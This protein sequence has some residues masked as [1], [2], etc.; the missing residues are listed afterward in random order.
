MNNSSSERINPITLTLLCQR[1]LE[2]VAI[3]HIFG[4]LSLSFDW[5]VSL[6]SEYRYELFQV[7]KLTDMASAE[8]NSIVEM[9]TQLFGPTV[10]SWGIL[11]FYL[12]RQVGG[13]SVFHNGSRDSSNQLHNQEKFVALQI[14]SAD[15]LI[16]AT[17]LWFVLDFAIS[18]NF[19]MML[20]LIINTVAILSILLPL[21]FL[22]LKLL[23]KGGNDYAT[24]RI[25]N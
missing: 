21:I 3:A 7:F 19:G 6:W 10:A 4:G 9:L 15:I 23:K 16:L 22:R 5:P 20:H 24:Y 18:M 11:M 12:V 14:S 17:L 2:L 13:K 25:E 8:I 1:W